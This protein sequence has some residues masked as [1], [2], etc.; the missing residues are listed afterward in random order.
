MMST[1]ESRDDKCT[2]WQIRVQL[3]TA[4]LDLILIDTEVC[5]IQSGPAV[6]VLPVDVYTTCTAY[7]HIHRIDCAH[8][9]CTICTAYLTCTRRL[10]TSAPYALH[11][12]YTPHTQNTPYA[13]HTSHTLQTP[14]TPRALHTPPTPCKRVVCYICTYQGPRNNNNSLQAFQL[15]VCLPGTS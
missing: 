13:L 1:A 8:T 9:T 12:S 11:T 10:H 7:P 5:C 14:L 3:A 15:M 2:T 6:T 4:I